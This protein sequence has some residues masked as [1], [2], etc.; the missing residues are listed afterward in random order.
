MMPY[1]RVFQKPSKNA[2]RDDALC[3][4][5]SKTIKECTS[6]YVLVF[7]A[8]MHKGYQQFRHPIQIGAWL[9]LTL[10]KKGGNR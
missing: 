6:D 10:N 9:D 1:V 4:R 2:L 3:T 7:D 5:I 8:R